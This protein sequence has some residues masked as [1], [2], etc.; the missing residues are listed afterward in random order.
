MDQLQ[1]FMAVQEKIKELT[2]EKIRRDERLKVE[3]LKLEKILDD[4][5]K[6]GYDPTKLSEIK[7]SKE[8]EL[9]KALAEL[10]G[11]VKEI[12]NKLKEIEEKNVGTNS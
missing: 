12:T 6:K 4:I 11:K 7:E 2:D 3:T 10:E 5:K 9:E 8:K 1:R